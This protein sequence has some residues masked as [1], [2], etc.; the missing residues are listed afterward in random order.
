MGKDLR[1][2]VGAV[3]VRVFLGDGIRGR[4]AVC[5]HIHP[6][7]GACEIAAIPKDSKSHCEHGRSF[8]IQHAL[9]CQTT[10]LT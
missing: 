7:D 10:D 4:A 9:L 2:L 5:V 8:D 1:W 3:E 6:Q